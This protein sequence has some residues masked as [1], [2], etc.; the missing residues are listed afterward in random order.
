MNNRGPNT[1]PCWTPLHDSVCQTYYIALSFDS[2][3]LAA[4]TE[5]KNETRICHIIWHNSQ[6]I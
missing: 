1:V 6:F 4:G 3:T 2:L 5:E